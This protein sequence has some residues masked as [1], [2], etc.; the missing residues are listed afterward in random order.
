MPSERILNKYYNEGAFNAPERIG[1]M[2]S[3]IRKLKPLTEEEWHIWYINNVHD[4]NYIM[5]I[6]EEMQQSIP[7]SYSI[8]VD[9]CHEYVIDVMFHRTFKGYN[10]ENL[11]LSYLRR[12]VSPNVQEAPKEWDTEYFID[13]YIDKSETHPLIGIQLKPDTFYY[14]H[15]QHVVDIEGKMR[16]FCQYYDALAYVLQYDSELTTDKKIVFQNPE[17]IDDIKD[18]L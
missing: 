17:T 10:R 8:T 12:F 5:D 18:N 6:A 13:F 14:G 2:M 15:Y 1:Y 9:D 16:R 3:Y 4:E 7:A 11:A